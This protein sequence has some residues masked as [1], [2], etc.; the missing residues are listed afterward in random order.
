MNAVPELAGVGL[1]RQT[2]IVV[3]EAAKKNGAQSKK[4]KRHTGTALR[5]NGRELLGLGA[6][7]SGTK[8]RW[9][10]PKLISAAT[11]RYPMQG[12]LPARSATRTQ[13]DRPHHRGGRTDFVSDRTHAARAAPRSVSWLPPHARGTPPGRAAVPRGVGHRPGDGSEPRAMRAHA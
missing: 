4:S 7:I 13:N 12:A 1:A 2:L 9:I 3:R 8:V 10:A 11:S 6:A 5:R